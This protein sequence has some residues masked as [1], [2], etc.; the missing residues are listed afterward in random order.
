MDIFS[1]YFFCILILFWPIPVWIILKWF[2]IFPNYS[3]IDPD[4]SNNTFIPKCSHAFPN[5][6]NFIQCRSQ[7]VFNYF[8]IFHI[9]FFLQTS[10]TTFNTFKHYSKPFQYYCK[11]FKQ[12]SKAFEHYSKPFELYSK[13]FQPYSKAFHH[14]SRIPNI[15]CFVFQ[16][17]VH[18]LWSGLLIVEMQKKTGPCFPLLLIE[19]LIW[20]TLLN[21]CPLLGAS[22]SLSMFSWL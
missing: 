4:H 18:E 21:L 19:G 11:P 8:V 6:S 3:R 20:I 12:D 22:L 14:Y 16:R 17:A 1:R 7:I 10:P 13:P 15:L 9:Y 5:Q 2:Y